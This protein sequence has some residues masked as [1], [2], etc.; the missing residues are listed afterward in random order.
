M[1]R[2]ALLWFFLNKKDMH[3]QTNMQKNTMSLPRFN[4]IMCMV[5]ILEIFLK[6]TFFVTLIFFE[7]K[8]IFLC[9]KII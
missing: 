9:L 7:K 6:T 2:F 8:H 3:L 4:E 5:Q 1:L